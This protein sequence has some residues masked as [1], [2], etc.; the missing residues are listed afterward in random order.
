MPPKKEEVVKK[1]PL[2]RPGNTLKMGIVGIPNVGKSSTFNL[3]SKLS[4]PAEN[5]PFCTKDPNK[6]KVFIKDPRFDKLVSIF[7]PKSA[8]EATIEVVDIAGLVKG[9][10]EGEGLG[11]AFL[12]NIQ[13]V[14]GIYHVVRAFED[15][16]IIH[17]EGEVDPVRDLEVISTE[18]IKKDLQM[19]NKRLDTL[20]KDI[21][22]FNN[23]QAKEEKETLDKVKAMLDN[24]QW[25]KDGTWSAKDIDILNEHLFFTAKPVIYMVN[26][27]E[28]DFKRKG[29]KWL[30]KIKEWIEKNC[31]GPIIPYSVAYEQA[32]L[33]E[34]EEQNEESKTA[35]AT[36]KHTELSM[37]PKIT[38]T[39]YK[40]LEL[41][42][43][44]TAG[45]DEV[46]CWTVRDGAKAPQAA[47]VIH[48]DFEKGFICAEVMKYDDFVELGSE[49]EVKAKG[50]LKTQGKEYVV[51]D[52]DI[53]HFKFNAPSKK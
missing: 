1:A 37:V 13:A 12:S 49:A 50:K 34:V 32:L 4:V 35:E 17:T 18:L 45:E 25:V 9:A 47:G 28:K 6:A 36:K 29:N 26:L 38:K 33:K 3:L 10:A 40:M 43:Y 51:Q 21:A 15:E 31:P 52:G 42:H 5:Y 20:E 16:E 8:V 23:K 41:I 44:F 39:G 22:R 48:T 27:S 11:N 7:K 2:G 30:T 53:M 19:L 24:L 14:D 46:K